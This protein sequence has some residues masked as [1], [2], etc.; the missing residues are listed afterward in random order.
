MRMRAGIQQ[1]GWN[2]MQAHNEREKIRQRI[3]SKSRISKSGCWIWTGTLM[4]AR[5]VNGRTFL[6]YGVFNHKAKTYRAHRMS[7]TVFKGEIPIGMLV[8]HKCDNP[9]CVNPNHLFIGSHQDNAT[10]CAKK[11]RTRKGNNS[12]VARLT[13]ARVIAAR[14]GYK[15][16]SK[17]H[18]CR[19]YAR[20]YGVS[21]SEMVMAI[22]GDRW[23]HLNSICMT[24]AVKSK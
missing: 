15:P 24:K 13:T 21:D 4:K 14:K 8:C 18:G 23:D 2:R 10:D 3:K 5:K 17:T 12:P 9:K 7:W 16:Y 6:P 19:A 1:K 22:H 20:K 11:N